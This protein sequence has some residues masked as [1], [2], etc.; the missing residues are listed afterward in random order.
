MVLLKVANGCLFVVTTDAKLHVWYVTPSACPCPT[1]LT[2]GA[3]RVDDGSKLHMLHS[4][5]D[6][7]PVLAG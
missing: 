2:V 7:A 3:R 4:N 1:P 6:L 5:H